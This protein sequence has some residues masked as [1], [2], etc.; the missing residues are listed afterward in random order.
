MDTGESPPDLK[1]EKAGGFRG[2]LGPDY[3][4]EEALMQLQGI[5]DNSWPKSTQNDLRRIR[6]DK[7]NSRCKH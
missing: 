3:C 7:D 1:S 5:Q 2:T 6:M 4:E